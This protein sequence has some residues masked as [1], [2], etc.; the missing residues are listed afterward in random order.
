MSI[1][2]SQSPA[3]D[4]LVG[5]AMTHYRSGRVAEAERLYRE[6]LTLR[7]DLALIHAGLALI[8]YMQ[9]RPQEA[10]AAFREAVKLE[11]DNPELLYKLGN[12]LLR[13]GA[14]GD[15]RIEESFACFA[16]H[17][18]LTFQPAT[19]PGEAAH[20]IKHD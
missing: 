9:G 13:D 8:L 6:A 20:R 12:M 2:V 17:A 5:Q 7:P 4:A 18:R 14:A 15:A 11:P 19:A 10:I 3:V 1:G 16:R